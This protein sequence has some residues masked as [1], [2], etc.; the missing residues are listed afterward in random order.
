[1]KDTVRK[2]LAM[3]LPIGGLAVLGLYTA[4][5]I[6]IVQNHMLSQ[7]WVVLGVIAAI[8]LAFF[9]QFGIVVFTR[10]RPKVRAIGYGVALLLMAHYTL[11]D[12]VQRNIFAGDIMTL[13]G[14]LIVFLTLA[15]W[16]VTHSVQKKIQE[17]KQVII[18]V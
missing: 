11:V 6:T 1:M 15:G 2:I 12:D 7:Q 5:N 4:Q 3:L 18:E 13:L 10:K 17:G 16:I 9:L 8:L 14:V